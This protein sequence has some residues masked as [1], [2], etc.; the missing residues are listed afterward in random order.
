MIQHSYYKK[1]KSTIYDT[2]YFKRI[3]S[4][5]YDTVYSKGLR[6]V[7]MIQYIQKD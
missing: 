5:I 1:I 6:V 2:A 3:K 4:S 7:S